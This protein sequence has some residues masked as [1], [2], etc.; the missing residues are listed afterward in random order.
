MGMGRWKKELEDHL[1]C[2]I[3]VDVQSLSKLHVADTGFH[4]RAC[5]GLSRG[6]RLKQCALGTSVMPCPWPKNPELTK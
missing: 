2:H 4:V 3:C 6:G 5:L 1:C